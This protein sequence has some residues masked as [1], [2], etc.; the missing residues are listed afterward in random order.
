LKPAGV[1]VDQT[2]QLAETH[3]PAVRNVADMDTPEEGKQM[4]LTQT[5]EGDVLHDDHV[6]VIVKGEERIAHDARWIGG[7]TLGEETKGISDPAWGVE[8]ALAVRILAELLEESRH[9]L[10]QLVTGRER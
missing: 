3:D 5:E 10:R 2:R 9:R 4:V 7:I 6:V 1:R 8:Q